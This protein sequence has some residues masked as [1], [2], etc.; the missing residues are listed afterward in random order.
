MI[1]LTNKQDDFINDERQQEA[2]N[3]VNRKQ[4]IFD[5]ISSA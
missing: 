2:S 5:A 3:E 1:E 4:A